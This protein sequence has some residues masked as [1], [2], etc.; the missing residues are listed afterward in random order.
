MS[1]SRSP[2]VLSI[3]SHTV[4]GY[5][6]NKA[7]TFP[8]QTMGFNVDCI[9]TVS[10]SNHPAYAAGCKGKALEDGVLTDIIS[11]LEA[12]A[13]MDYDIILTGYTRSLQH[14]EIM[15]VTVKKVRALRPDALYL[16]DPVL[17]DNGSYYVPSE[18]AEVYKSR[19]LPLAT[20]VT[21]NL[22]EC[23]VLAGGMRITDLPSAVLAAQRIH[24]LGPKIVIMTGLS[25]SSSSEGDMLTALVSS[26]E[27][28]Y[29]VRFPRIPGYYAGCGD[30]LSALACAGLHT[31]K[32]VRRHRPA[33]MGDLL[34]VLVTALR[35]VMTATA[36]SSG[37]QGQ[38]QG[39][40]HR[41]L[42]IVESRQ[43]FVRVM[44]QFLRI[45]SGTGSGTT[46]ITADRGPRANLIQGG[47][48][49]GAGGPLGVIF[50]MDGT[51]TEA[52]AIDFP[53]MHARSG[54]PRGTK[55]ILT[56]IRS[57]PSEQ[58]GEAL[59]IVHEE[60]M[61]GCERAVLRQHFHRLLSLLDKHKLR[62]ALSTR[63]C[64]QAV[65]H[66]HTLSNTS[67]GVFSP[68]LHRDSLQGINKPDERV[69]QAVLSAWSVP[70]DMRGNVWF[71]G[72]GLDDMRCARAAGCRAV[73]L[74]T[75][76]N[77]H[78]LEQHPELVDEVVRDL[79]HLIE[80]MGLEEEE[81][82]E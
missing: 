76:H 20:V 13:L 17:G 9:N 42:A 27:G 45:R 68:S 4:H 5:V 35:D 50:D 80:L 2:R 34:E 55:D 22:F 56:A 15:E 53:A 31:L 54:L 75:E 28:V 41:E 1:S 25:L 46:G 47:A 30:L 14:L 24:A 12:N 11:G 48:R 64:P 33:C 69:A 79:G 71:V 58:Q 36:T 21:P 18:L 43:V 6:G 60:E 66:F 78:L 67:S 10:L 72:D 7:A 59:R 38:G 82:E 81:E 16:C 3:Q 65:Q 32:E 40:G 61:L 73:L 49:G 74:V 37:A 57:L 8:L 63:N 52:G 19:L 39:Q 23:E 51:L 26:A 29:E 62:A 77:K 70:Q 44:E